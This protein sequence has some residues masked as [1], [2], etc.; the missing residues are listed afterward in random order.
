[1][2]VFR[3]NLYIIGWLADVYM[4]RFVCAFVLDVELDVAAAI[5]RGFEE[6]AYMYS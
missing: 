4:Y 3:T 5:E 2:L 1:M 6:L